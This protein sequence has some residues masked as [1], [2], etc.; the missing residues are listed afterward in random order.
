[1]GHETRIKC[2][3]KLGRFFTQAERRDPDIHSSTMRRNPILDETKSEF[4]YRVRKH[5]KKMKKKS[6]NIWN[7]THTLVLLQV[8]KNINLERDPHVEYLDYVKV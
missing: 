6:G 2:D 4:H 1:M 3:P 7:I 8:A 5:L